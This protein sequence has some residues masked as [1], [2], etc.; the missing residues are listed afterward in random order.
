MMPEGKLIAVQGATISCRN[1]T[2]LGMPTSNILIS[3]SDVETCCCENSIL[4]INDDGVGINIRPFQGCRLTSNKRC[5]PTPMVAGGTGWRKYAQPFA[6]IDEEI[7]TE[8]SYF[9]CAIGMNIVKISDPGQEDLRVGDELCDSEFY[10]F[11]QAADEAFGPLS[12][13]QLENIKTIIDTFIRLGDG[14]VNKLAYILTTVRHESGFYSIREQTRFWAGETNISDELARSRLGNARYA[15]VDPV[16][17]QAYYGRGFVQL[18]WKDNYETM[19]AWLSNEY[20]RE[21]DLVNNPDLMLTNPEYAAAATVYGMME[22][23]YAGDGN[24]LDYYINS[25]NTNNPDFVGAR[26][27]VNVQDKAH[28]IAGNTEILLE[29]Y[30]ELQLLP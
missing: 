21:I 10:D 11:I 3:T 26:Y 14:D 5:R 28:E 12:D 23:S 8:D 15:R 20:N 7:L 4:T 2:V 18:T 22:G 19:S 1:S 24:G 13:E 27:T 30:Q 16:T 6:D 17:G 25:E 9:V 29:E